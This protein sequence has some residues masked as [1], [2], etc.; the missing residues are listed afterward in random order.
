M[1]SLES[2]GEG[3]LH[4][5]VHDADVAEIEVGHMDHSYVDAVCQ[6]YNPLDLVSFSPYHL[7]QGHQ[8]QPEKF[9]H[10]HFFRV[11]FAKS[12]VQDPPT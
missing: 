1:H 11:P 12:E 2:H 6:G 10:F 9:H 8:I 5:G 4:E 3:V 7:L